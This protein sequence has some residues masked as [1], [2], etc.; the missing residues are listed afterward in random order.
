MNTNN[1]D[2]LISIANDLYWEICQDWGN[3]SDVA[4]AIEGVIVS[5]DIVSPKLF[6]E[7]IKYEMI[8][9]DIWDEPKYRKLWNKIANYKLNTSVNESKNVQLTDNMYS[10]FYAAVDRLYGEPFYMPELD[11]LY[12]KEI[13][14]KEYLMILNDALYDDDF[15]EDEREEIKSIM[16]QVCGDY[17]VD[18]IHSINSGKPRNNYY[19]IAYSVFAH[20]YVGRKMVESDR[21]NPKTIL[22]RIFGQY[23]EDINRKMVEKLEADVLDAFGGIKDDIKKYGHS[24]LRTPDMNESKCPKSGCIKKKPNGKWGI[25]SAKTGK[26]WK[27]NY[28][29]EADAKD[30]LKA[31]HVNEDVDYDEVYM[32]IYADNI[33]SIDDIK[34]L[35][36]IDDANIIFEDTEQ[37]DFYTTDALNL[38]DD[39][40]NHGIVWEEDKNY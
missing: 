8:N 11:N 33:Y 39:L 13:P 18:E 35:F 30:G 36:N 21:V 23:L 31:Y 4:Y 14:Y 12:E 6:A 37:I 16:Q 24:V 27:A 40:D 26:F 34:E 20:I 29:T 15:S 2:K 9:Y 32:S 38:Q 5:S 19:D 22:N 1:E 7:E 25:I 17:I 3:D 10:I 28:D